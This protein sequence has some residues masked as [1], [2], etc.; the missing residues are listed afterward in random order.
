MAT[1]SN[2]KKPS[3]KEEDNEFSFRELLLK[4]L[5][6]L[7]LFA[8]FLIVSFAI[9]LVY[10]QFQTP[11]FSTSI[12][13]LVKNAQEG[14]NE[15]AVLSDL[16]GPYKPNLNNEMEVVRSQRLMEKWWRR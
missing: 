8:I 13:L 1:A 7:P 10:V 11:L 14:C 6:Y 3:P 15:S 5:N 12:K 2:I 9:D 16:M 4:S